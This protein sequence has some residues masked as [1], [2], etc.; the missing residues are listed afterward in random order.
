MASRTSPHSTLHFVVDHHA[1]SLA[2]RSIYITSVHCTTPQKKSDIVREFSFS[3]YPVSTKRL[4]NKETLGYYSPWVGT[5]FHRV[6]IVDAH[7]QIVDLVL[8]CK[9]AV[10]RF[11]QIRTE[12]VAA[13]NLKTWRQM[14]RWMS[15]GW[16]STYVRMPDGCGV[17]SQRRL[18]T[19]RFLCRASFS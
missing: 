2:P 5:P 9:G 16:I 3:I 19:S 14:R 18:R 11:E 17:V 12:L 8:V 4:T 15:G 7:M 6:T 1:Q 10:R 13:K